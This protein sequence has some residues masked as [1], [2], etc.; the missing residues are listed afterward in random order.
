M[1]LMADENCTKIKVYRIN[2]EAIK[3]EKY[4]FFVKLQEKIAEGGDDVIIMGDLNG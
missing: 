1:K 2:E 4:T 3:E